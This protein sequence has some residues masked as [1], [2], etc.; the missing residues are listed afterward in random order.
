MIGLPRLCRWVL[1]MLLL[2][3]GTTLAWKMEAGTL[4]LPATSG[5]SDLFAFSFQQV[6]DTPPVVVALP[7]NDGPN[8]SDL[9]IKDVTT[10]GFRI[11]QVEPFSED[12]P[13]TNM[14]V[15]YVAVEPGSHV[16]PDG[17]RIEAGLL[18]SKQSSGARRDYMQFNG[19]N[20]NSAAWGTHTFTS[21]FTSA[22]VVLGAIQT[23][24]NE[25]N[26]VPDAVSNPWLTTVFNAVT[27]TGF[28]YALERS[29]VYDSRAGN[30]NNYFFDPLA[31]V[32]S[33]GYIAVEPTTGGVFR[34]V[35]NVN[36]RFEARNFSNAVVGWDDGCR[37]LA[38]A[39]AFSSAPVAVASK[40]SRREADGGW[41]RQCAL[42]SSSLSLTIDEDTA[43][44]SER[45]HGLEDASLLAFSEAFIYDSEYTPPEPEPLMMEAR[46]VTVPAGVFT[47]V[48]FEQVY[49]SA[50]AVFVLGDDGNPEPS[51][52][53]IRNVTA[54][55]FDLAPAEP[56]SR[57]GDVADD[58]TT[59]HFLA[60]TY[61]EHQLPNG[62][63]RLE[64]GQ[65]PVSAYQGKFLSGTSW[66]RLNFLTAFGST[67]TL[68]TALQ[69][70]ANETAAPVGRSVP[71][72]TLAHRNLGATGIDLALDRAE[73]R[74]GQILQPETVAYL[75][76]E[77]GPIPEFVDNDGKRVFGEAQ[78]TADTIRGT[79]S[80]DNAAFLQNYS[81]APLVIGSQV[82]RDGG[83][84]G[85]LRRCSVTTA[86]VFLKI[87]EDWANDRDLSHTTE[88]AAFVAFSEPFV[89]DF[90]LRAVYALEGPLWQGNPGE[91]V[92]LRGT[93]LDG[94]AVN[95]ARAEPARVCY[96][97]TLTGGAYIDVPDADAL[98]V[99]DELT[100]MAWI[101]IDRIPSS[102][103]STI[104]SKDENYEY[105]VNSNGEIY[106]WWNTDSGA[107]RFFETTGYTVPT[108]TWVH[109]AITYS[110][111]DGL[112]RILV[113]GVERARQTY[114]NESLL[115]T[116]DPFQIGA[117][118]GFAGREFPGQIDEVRLYGR[119]L[120]DAA[121]LR[122]ANRTRPCAQVLDHFRV[123]VPATASVCA[124]LEVQIQAEDAGNNPL[125]GYQ[126]QVS[127]STSAGHGNWSRISA[128]GTLS[129]SPDA[130]DDG[131]ASYQFVPAD[132]GAITLGLSN[133][134]A[135]TLTIRVE[136]TSG[137]QFG[138][139]SPVTF[140]DNA[141]VVSVT[142][143]FADDVIAGR[144]HRLTAEVLSRDPV[145]GD[146]GRLAAYDGPV[147]F[148]AWLDRQGDDPGGSA[149]DLSGGAASVT[150][151]D[152][153]PGASN[154]TLVFDQGAAELALAPGDVGHYSVQF[155][156]SESGLIVDENGAAKTLVGAS[157]PLSV[158]PFSFAVS[159]PGNPAANVASG[160]AFQ[161]AG[162]PFDVRV[163][164]VQYDPA[165]DANLDGRPDGHDDADPTNNVSLADNGSTPSFDAGVGVDGYLTAGPTGA[166]DPG[167]A[168]LASVA[169]FSGGESAGT[170]AFNEVGAIEIAARYTGNY[171][172]RAVDLRGA[173]GPV[174]R[175]HPE[176]FSL[177]SQSDG[178]FAAGCNGFSYTGERFGYASAPQFTLAARAYAASGTGPI[179]RNY[180]E[181]W[182][183]LTAADVI[184]NDPSTDDVQTGTDGSL[185][186]VNSSP[187][188]A[189]L[190]PVGNG[191]L[192]YV[193][194]ADEFDYVRDSAARVAPFDARL[195]VRIT[196]ATDSDGVAVAPSDLPIVLSPLGPSI[197]Y[198]RLALENAYGPETADLEV[199][200]EAQ[201]WN[202]S[203]FVRHQDEICWAYNTA[204]AVI[205]D[206][207][208][209][210][211]V[212]PR[213]GVF[214]SGAPP[215]GQ[216]LI[217]GQ[218]GAGNT[219]QV[220]VRYP[221]PAYWQYD[222]DGDGSDEDPQAI[223][224]FG[225]YR[226]HDRVIYWQE[227]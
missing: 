1:M 61:G 59:V 166:S 206:T 83:D 44:D 26:A 77:S 179:T 49:P 176:A 16:L 143:A 162:R 219:G 214:D 183:K 182:Q 9:R 79:T 12:G 169:G 190:T 38:F 13:H 21:S 127:L 34:A 119:A 19:Q 205:T 91:V 194:G 151:P 24:N 184:R 92:E 118:Q 181:D 30:S 197:R 63:P 70:T 94:R 15:S 5:E 193:L 75:A 160:P 135:D 207:P 157:V 105:H 71:W 140:Q 25:T 58:T 200:M 81:T 115:T 95:G 128:S 186:A 131:A 153:R 60:V 62:G 137:G 17:T 192:T 116:S 96:G 163:R 101:K 27:A 89:A 133:R 222:Y 209:N 159:V 217:L 29:E 204:D 54:E 138:V 202:G 174:G 8:A 216:A 213:A 148:R 6:Y 39:N 158:R 146:C 111:R 199:P 141:L 22:P 227:R 165:D 36:I 11:A 100:L 150:L 220:T 167:L 76:I 99:S 51:S 97:A 32:E 37:A 134:R 225:V 161:A 7:T 122:E 35:G 48:A 4:T 145:T 112:Q 40:V 149:P 132:N 211:S 114:A 74:T 196:S 78:V 155:E 69:T 208:P 68:V 198:G 170:A 191:T 139:S 14:T 109:T 103:L 120:S 90:S 18:S 66:A 121:I 56:P 142:D 110:R 42:T 113:N 67:P 88:R 93:G 147:G 41:L 80:C 221:V 86:D 64:V 187:G 129:P 108:G 43:Q 210:T 2:W 226:G 130:D 53:R 45:R 189:T 215:S 136:D 10:T 55:G 20:S 98:D 57:F 171:L 185:L 65:L 154:L 125:V 52:V 175:F 173:S 212:S 102:D 31:Q 123:T 223:A 172:G 117:D 106:W 168:G 3:P 33:I 124:P 107:T 188:T 152:S 180:R 218:P 104:V 82:T 195:S 72:M 50:P 46:S 73:T 201:I 28:D 126:G 164:A 203:R 177:E 224:T 47:R 156:D 84:G 23:L 87:E 178:A 144:P 85:W